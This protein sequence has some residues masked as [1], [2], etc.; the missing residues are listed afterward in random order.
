VQS[1]EAEL[2]ASR[3]A[4]PREVEREVQRRIKPLTDKT[5]VLLAEIDHLQVERQDMAQA[6]QQ[7]VKHTFRRLLVVIS[8]ISLSEYATALFP[9]MQ[10]LYRPLQ[11]RALEA[12][13]RS[14]HSSRAEESERSLQVL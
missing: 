10:L 2:D 8:R 12:E 14:A 13:V 4:L 3:A 6:H 11:M 1:L 7:Q 5:G 9:Y